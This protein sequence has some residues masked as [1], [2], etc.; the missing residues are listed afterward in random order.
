MVSATA[1]NK[2]R[3][4]IAFGSRS[5]HPIEDLIKLAQTA[6][7]LGYDAAFF[8]ESWGRDLVSL[9]TVVALIT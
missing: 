3:V 2:Q 4:A 7:S 5:V 9:L 6:E 1:V 8:G